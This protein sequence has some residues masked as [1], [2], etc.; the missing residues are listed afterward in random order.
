[1]SVSGSASQ[2]GGVATGDGKG[3]A[4]K[5]PFGVAEAT[6]GY[7]WDWNV[8]IPRESLDR[9]K[10]G[11][12][13]PAAQV[14][15]NTLMKEKS[16]PKISVNV[17]GR[18]QS[19]LSSITPISTNSLVT[20]LPAATERSPSYHNQLTTSTN[21][22][23][24]PAP[25]TS[26]TSFKVSDVNKTSGG[27]PAKVKYE[28]TEPDMLVDTPVDDPSMIPDSASGGR[29]ELM[30]VSPT[31][32]IMSEATIAAPTNS[33]RDLFVSKGSVTKSELKHT[34]LDSDIDA[35]LARAIGEDEG[36][37]E[38]ADIDADIA[39]ALGDEKVSKA[40]TIKR[41]S[42]SIPQLSN[43]RAA[44]ELEE[45]LVGGSNDENNTDAG[46]E[47]DQLGVGQPPQPPDEGSEFIF[48]E[49]DYIPASK[50]GTLEFS[51]GASLPLATSSIRS[52]SHQ[53]PS[54]AP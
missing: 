20:R 24:P 2:Y 31:S 53:S 38:D 8:K 30:D 15:G 23:P 12:T 21:M 17:P 28:E 19:T 42:S 16:V 29:N 43:H 32:Q 51:S 36:D 27:F 18:R 10:Y 25:S 26:V 41:S 35:E 13:A 49:M 40:T 34:S 1:M 50:A 22:P 14:Q 47:L 11:A 5:N 46:Q 45:L 52:T 44:S 54:N 39:E 4:D 7:T 9:V 33:S 37:D 48:S 6:L 3:R